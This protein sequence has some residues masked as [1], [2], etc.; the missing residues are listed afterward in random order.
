MSRIVIVNQGG[1]QFAVNSDLTFR[2]IDGGALKLFQTFSGGKDITLDLAPV[3]NIDSA[4]LALLIEWLRLARNRRVR[5]RFVNIPE[6][7]QKLAKLSGFEA[8]KWLSQQ[9]EPKES[10]NSRIEPV[11][12]DA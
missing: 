4:G 2:T 11:I 9:N 5:L 12:G 6:Q 1:G 10:R 8:A 3:D 7:L